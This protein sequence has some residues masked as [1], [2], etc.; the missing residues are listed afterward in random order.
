VVEITLSAKGSKRA[1][2]GSLLYFSA[3]ASHIPPSFKKSLALSF[4]FGFICLPLSPLEE[5][6]GQNI[7]PHQH[8]GYT[9]VIEYCAHGTHVRL[10]TQRDVNK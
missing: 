8:L 1:V 10:A 3:T 2:I 5:N 9:N 7:M 6:E 4:Y